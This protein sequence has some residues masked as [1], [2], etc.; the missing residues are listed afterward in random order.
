M[1]KQLFL[2]TILFLIVFTTLFNKLFT[3]QQVQD[4]KGAFTEIYDDRLL[5]ENYIY[6]LTDLFYKKKLSLLA[7]EKSRD[8]LKEWK[9]LQ[10][11]SNK[12]EDVVQRYA[13]T[14]L[15]TQEELIFQR[16]QLAVKD[17]RLAES[18]LRTENSVVITTTN[19]LCDSALALLQQLSHI[20]LSEAHV[21]KERGKTTLVSA[22]LAAQLEWVVCIFLPAL[23][24]IFLL[25]RQSFSLS[26]G[27]HR[28]N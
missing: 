2:L 7:L 27:G 13:K 15:S 19:N 25:K 1:K 17:I 24:L 22:H 12:L 11:Q 6:Q 4:L 9:T 18:E 20:Q 23:T 3:E 14:K 5:A 26:L 28:L 10:H 16:I 21:L 8:P